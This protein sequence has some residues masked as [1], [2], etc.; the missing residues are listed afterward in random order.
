MRRW[1]RRRWS[2]VEIDVMEAVEMNHDD[3]KEKETINET[4]KK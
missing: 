2:I 1:S 4:I 3:D